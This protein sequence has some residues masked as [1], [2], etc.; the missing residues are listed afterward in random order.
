MLRWLEAL[1]GGRGQRA[2]LYLLPPPPMLS[3][4]I[5]GKGVLELCYLLPT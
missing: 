3:S 2:W 5:A 1:G 4:Q